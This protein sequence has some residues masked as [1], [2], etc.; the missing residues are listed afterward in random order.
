MEGEGAFTRG[1]PDELCFGAARAVELVRL[2]DEESRRL[3]EDPSSLG[4]LAREAFR[5]FGLEPGRRLSEA[6]G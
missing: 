1:T 4:E 2:T 5:R 3:A 6:R